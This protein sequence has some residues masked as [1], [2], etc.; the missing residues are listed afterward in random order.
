[1]GELNMGEKIFSVIKKYRYPIL[2]LLLGILLMTI[3]M[4]TKTQTPQQTVPTYSQKE[5]AATQLK[6]LLSCIQGAGKVELYLSVA[7]G[8]VTH[9]L[10]DEEISADGSTS[11]IHRDTVI[12]TGADKAQSGIVMQVTPPKYLGA[13]VV[14]QG[15]DSAAVRLAMV[16]AVS[17]AT[18][19][20]SDK[21]TVLKMK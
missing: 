17:K 15:A 9:Y 18:G 19:L 4:K 12:V 5:D 6:Q 14:C 13:V 21:I 16:D 3:P 20:G 7:E 11:D 2:I 8:E 10:Q 1:M